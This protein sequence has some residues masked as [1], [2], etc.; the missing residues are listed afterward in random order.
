MKKFTLIAG[1]LC[2]ALLAGCGNYAG[3]WTA[4]SNS[5][6]T[7]NPTEMTTAL[8]DQ[9]TPGPYIGTFP[10][11]PLIVFAGSEVVNNSS[12]P[13]QTAQ[14]LVPQKY[15][16]FNESLAGSSTGQ[17]LEAAS[18]A[19]DPFFR[20][21]RTENILVVWAGQADL[22]NG[23]TPGLV[24]DNL[25][26]YCQA[27]RAVGFKVVVVTLLPVNSGAAQGSYEAE[28]QTLNSRL[29]SQWPEFADALA[30]VAALPALASSASPPISEYSQAQ[31]SHPEATESGWPAETIKTAIANLF[32]N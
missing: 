22:A 19:I 17:M 4:S 27:R 1:L 23:A 18:W 21:T 7:A 8:T 5:A 9:P 29:R 20:P 3:S 16:Y 13:A 25:M 28:R 24:F 10:T 32:F 15:D 6:G 2:A 26:A 30:D 11:A 31:S 14:L 12:L